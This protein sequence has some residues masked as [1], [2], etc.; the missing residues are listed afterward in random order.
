MENLELYKQ[1]FIETF[2]LREDEIGENTTMDNIEL[3]DSVGHI[4]LV[5]SI[6]MAF[7][8]EMSLED[9]SALTSF[10]GGKEILKKYGIDI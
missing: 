8:I 7:D 4:N 10:E 6:E 5:V 3:W 2:T 9:V 1:A